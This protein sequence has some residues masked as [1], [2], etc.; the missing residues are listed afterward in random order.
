MKKLAGLCFIFLFVRIAF[1]QSVKKP[2]PEDQRAQGLQE[3]IWL[4]EKS[5]VSQVRWRNI[6]PSIMGGRVVD[7]HANPQDPT[8]FYI[9]YASGGLWYTH[10]NGQSFLPIFDH[11]PVMTI[12]AFAV[13]WKDH[14]LWVGTG[15]ANSSRSSYAGNGIYK[16]LDQGKTWQYL[17]LPESQ[18][19]GK[20]ILDPGHKNIAWVA[21]LGHLYSPNPQRGVYKTVDGGLTWKKVLFLDERTGAIDLALDPQDPRILYASLWYRMR[22]PWNFIA[23]GKTSGI[24]KSIDGGEHWKNISNSKSG[25]PTGSGVGRI[26]LAIYPKDP[27]IIYAIVDNNNLRPPLPQDSDQYAPQI[28]KSMNTEAFENLDTNKLNRFLH[29]HHFPKKYSSSSLKKLILTGSLKPADLYQYLVKQGEYPNQ[30]AVIGAQ[31]YRSAN[32]GRTWVK[33][34]LNFLDLY[35]DYGYY[36]GKI[37]VS[38]LDSDKIIIGG[39]TLLLSSNGGKTF[40]DIDAP[41]I[42]V[43]HH[44][45]WFD[46]KNDQHIIEGN[47]GGVNLTY[48]QGLHWN[49][50]NNMAVGQFYSVTVDNARPFNVYGGLQD[51][52]VWWGPSDNHENPGWYA[53]GNYPFKRLDD[54]DGMQVQVDTRDNNTLYCGSQFGYYT[55]TQR[56][57][58]HANEIEIHHDNEIEIHPKADLGQPPYRWNWETPILLSKHNQDILYMGSDQFHRSMNQGDSIKTLSGDLTLG[59]KKGNVPY[60]TLTTIQES[61]L[62]FGLIYIGT[63]DG[64]IQVSEDDGYTWK[65]R[66]RGLPKGL[67]VSAMAPSAFI[68]GRV[69]LCLNGSRFD[70]FQPY[71]FSSEDMGK[72]WCKIGKNLPTLP[73]NTVKE[74]PQNPDLLYVGTDNGVYLSLDRGTTFMAMTG[75]LPDVPVYDMAIQKESDNLVLGTHGRSIYLTSLKYIQKLKEPTLSSEL[76]IFGLHPPSFQK[77]WGSQIQGLSSVPNWRIP[78]FNKTAGIN[79]IRILTM[80]G[81]PLYSFQD[82]AVAG[83]NFPLY[84]LQ[85]DTTLRKMNWMNKKKLFTPPRLSKD[86]KCY[87]VPGSYQIEITTPEGKQV[88]RSFILR[89]KTSHPDK[90]NSGT[91]S[92]NPQK[93]SM[94]HDPEQ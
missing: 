59:A 25:F 27:Q 35:S 15:E 65:L 68:K 64:N 81:N 76:T 90:T 75:G 33:A 73:L 4:K 72:H 46:P 85:V 71:L 43:D 62:R 26:G 57:G 6:G 60:G 63:D 21:V 20:I 44:A 45:L 86:G 55:R 32:A 48:D 22:K 41:N 83:L 31:I 70:N 19:I 93:E 18:H 61:P 39:I 53:E 67:W 49:R 58:Q 69:Y 10:N 16:S 80:R 77:S 78:Y 74:D 9:A 2:T 5:L 13:N 88:K 89:K 66:T 36:F 17:G 28:F 14:I 79:I 92:P 24:F 29:H 50:C 8:E 23:S 82:T 11:E 40:S 12:G 1:S 42:H 3:I 47:D 87:L 7:I 84:H 52:G 34:N 51:N 94:E 30:P 37:W 56:H 91:L 38:P 54:G